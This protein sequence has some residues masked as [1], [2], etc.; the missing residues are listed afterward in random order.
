MAN[1][2]V[3]IPTKNEEL[4]IKSIIRGLRR[5]I[6]GLGHKV[7]AIIVTD[8]SRDSTRKIA[9]QEGGIVVNGGGKGLGL[10]MHK[11][12]KT[13]L[14]YHPDIIVSVDGDGQSDLSEIQKVI[15]P[16]IDDEADMVVGS[17]FQ[18]KGLV[19]YDYHLVNRIGI[20]I[21]VRILRMFTRMKLTDSHGGLRAMRPE[22]VEE[23]EMIGTHTYVQETIIDATEKGFRL[24]EIPSVW[25]KREFGTSRVV[26]NIPLYMFYT[27]PVLILRSGHH[28]K[29]IYTL[30]IVFMFLSLLDF[31]IVGVQ[32]GFN[33]G[34]MFERQSFHLI[35]LLI[36]IGLQLFSFGFILELITQIKYKVDRLGL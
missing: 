27:L 16:I 7:G 25:G 35:A 28:I 23:L 17:R 2:C 32:T 20:F 22:V 5:E 1:I 34:T 18:E 11:G 12:L 36:S 19:K 6:E 31:I 8:D 21:L 4:T 15:R 9:K 10:A 3:V 33:L 14:K 13:S 29:S 24:K 30:G 26:G